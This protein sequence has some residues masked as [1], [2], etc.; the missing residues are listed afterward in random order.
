MTQTYPLTITRNRGFY[1]KFRAL[2]IY[3]DTPRGAERLGK[4][5]QGKSVT[6]QVPQDAT[7]IYGKMDWGKSETIELAH[8]S[9]SETIYANAF[10]T[11]NPFRNIGTSNLPIRFETAP[12]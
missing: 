5:S 9:A 3:V 6:V 10:F 2:Q 8:V 7:R 1:G 12:R 11:F 4:V